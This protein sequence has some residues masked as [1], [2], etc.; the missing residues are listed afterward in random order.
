M[1]LDMAMSMPQTKE[2]LGKIPQGLHSLAKS[3]NTDKCFIMIGIKEITPGVEKGVIQIMGI[4]D[5]RLSLLNN[6][7]G[8][9]A[10][11]VVDESAIAM[12]RERMDKQR[13]EDN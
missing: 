1:M 5:G 7:K 2:Y 12:I 11:Y 10:E 9:P 4:V 13:E 8:E 6:E 3:F